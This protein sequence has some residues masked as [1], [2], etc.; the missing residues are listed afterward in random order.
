MIFNYNYTLKWMINDSELKSQLSPHVSPNLKIQQIFWLQL[1]T[2][3][4]EEMV[5]NN[6][7]GLE[8]SNSA[9]NILLDFWGKVTPSILH[10]ASYSKQV[11]YS[12]CQNLRHWFYPLFDDTKLRV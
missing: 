11:I 8:H 6:S 3:Y 9:M 4:L 2:V 12:C 7:S 10:L 5:K 1:W